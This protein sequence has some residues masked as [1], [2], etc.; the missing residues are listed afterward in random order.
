MA[1]ELSIQMS[2][3]LN[4]DGSPQAPERVIEGSEALK[5]KWHTVP[6]VVSRS[7]YFMSLFLIEEWVAQNC[8]FWAVLA[9]TALLRCPVSCHACLSSCRPL[10]GTGGGHHSLEVFAP[11]LVLSVR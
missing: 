2:G 10:L 5:G 1:A 9:Q 8:S 11:V 6:H 4:P 3:S 7:T